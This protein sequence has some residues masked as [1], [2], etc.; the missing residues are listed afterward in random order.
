SFDFVNATRL[1]NFIDSRP[2]TRKILKWVQQP[3]DTPEGFVGLVKLSDYHDFLKDQERGELS[4]RIF[5]SNVR[6][7]WPKTPINKE[8]LSTLEKSQE[9]PE[10]WLLN[11]GI[12]VLAGDTSNAGHLQIEIHDPQIVN[13]LQTSRVIYDYY[14]SNKPPG[15]DGR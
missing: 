7:F 2:K 14:R 5:D 8:I 1:W 10:F 15:D 13:G 9:S 12:T 3:L 11:N 6:G 4:K